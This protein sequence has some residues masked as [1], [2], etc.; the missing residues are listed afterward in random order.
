[1]AGNDALGG[2]LASFSIEE[3]SVTFRMRMDCPTS[4]AMRTSILA[5]SSVLTLRAAPVFPVGAYRA[6]VERVFPNLICTAG[7]E[8]PHWFCPELVE[9]R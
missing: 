4:T 8:A 1:M 9:F 3:H 7:M 6:S 5:L 2:G